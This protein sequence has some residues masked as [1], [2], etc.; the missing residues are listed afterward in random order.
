MNMINVKSSA[1]SSIGYDALTKK[2]KIKFKYGHAYSFCSVPEEI[3]KNFLNSSS[4]GT[5]YQK[6]IKDKFNCF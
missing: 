2:M 6:H 3:Y 1:I 5:F 4:K